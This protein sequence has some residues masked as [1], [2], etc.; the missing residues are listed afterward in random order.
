MLINKRLSS[1][2]EFEHLLLFYITIN[3]A[4]MHLFSINCIFIVM[5]QQN[6]NEF[7]NPQ[8]NA[9]STFQFNDFVYE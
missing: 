9:H 8:K 5:I 3:V 7:I 2:T 4:F 1:T 6:D